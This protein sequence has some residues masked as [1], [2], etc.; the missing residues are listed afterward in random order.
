VNVGFVGLGKLGL[1]VALAIGARGHAVA[2]WDESAAARADAE[3]RR[4]PPGERPP[5][6]VVDR[7]ELRV[8]AIDEVV[9]AEIVFV[10][11]QTPHEPALEGATRLPDHRSDFDYSYLTAAVRSLAAAAEA[12]RASPLVAVISTVLPGTV[13]RDVAPLLP[14]GVEVAYNPFFTAMGTTIADFLEPEFVLVGVAGGAGN[15]LLDRFYRTIHER[16]IFTTDIRTAELIKVA[17]N[18]FIGQ[19]IVF[20]NAMM[21]I[22]HKVGGNADDLTRALALASERIVSPRY[23]RGGM[24]DGGPCHPRDNIAL[25]WLSERL[26]LSHDIFGDIME[27]RE[28]QTEWLADLIAER[29]DGL[30]VVLLGK[31]FKPESHLT[32]GS[33]A[34]LLASIL[35]ERGVEFDHH[36][37]HVDG[38]GPPIADREPSLFFV[39]TGHSEYRDA[40]FPRGSVVLDP[41]GLIDDQDGVEVVRIGRR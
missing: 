11:V 40:A 35:A 39:A 10:A 23:L 16:P 31:A 2:G 30:P 28:H 38:A 19:K 1:P 4:L 20:A 12:E 25:S 29:A 7:S 18:T 34:T 26:E 13:E 21:E 3:A 8:A 17:Y 6:D 9:R 32:A 14:A 37:P 27:A 5:P 24:G 36:D 15:P 33:P 22:A 41:W